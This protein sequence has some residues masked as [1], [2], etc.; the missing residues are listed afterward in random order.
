M[1]NQAP[2]SLLALLL[3]P[4]NKP[5]ASKTPQRPTPK[6]NK[7]TVPLPTWFQAGGT[8]PPPPWPS[9]L[10][11][12]R[13]RAER[14]RHDREAAA[15]WDREKEA[16]YAAVEGVWGKRGGGALGGKRAGSRELR[17]WYAGY[18]KQKGKESRLDEGRQEGK[19]GKS[20]GEGEAAGVSGGGRDPVMSGG[21]GGEDDSAGRVEK[22]EGSDEGDVGGIGHDNGSGD[23]AGN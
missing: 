15:A 5:K 3:L 20:E 1:P 9:F 4:P 13:R 18:L 2:P 10:S 21:N 6:P 23:G 12:A 8:G 19:G 16:A 22:G 11:L 17:A 14:T 7:G